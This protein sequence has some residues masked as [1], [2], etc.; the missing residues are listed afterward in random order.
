MKWKK[1]EIK[2]NTEEAKDQRTDNTSGSSSQEKSL[3]TLK[4]GR[5]SVN[6]EGKF[7]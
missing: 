3:A 7:E 2:R 4:K 6:S 5:V 1:P